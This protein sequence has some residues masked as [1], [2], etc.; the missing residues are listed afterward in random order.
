M[1]VNLK[2]PQPLDSLG[3]YVCGPLLRMFLKSEPG[4]VWGEVGQRKW[5]P[6]SWDRG[7]STDP[8]FAQIKTQIN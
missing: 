5:D 3:I 8:A 6:I 4:S 7:Q 2:T 1:T